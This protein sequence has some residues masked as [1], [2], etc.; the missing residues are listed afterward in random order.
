[1]TTPD[2]FPF[3]AR[4]VDVH[5]SRMHYIDE[6]DGA[7]VLFIHG[8]P[9]SSY[10]WRNVIPHV[11]P[12]ARAVAV[13][14]IG[15]GKSDQPDLPYRFTDHYRYLEG[16][17]DAL[18]LQ[19]VTLV[20][21]DWGGGLGTSWARRHPDRV[22]G[23]VFMESVLMPMDLADTDIVTRFVFNRM[24]DPKKGDRMN[25]QK[26]FFLKR[27]MPMMT[28]TRLSPAAKAAYLAPFSTPESRKPV[29]Q[30]PREIPLG[31]HPE[32]MV[33]EIGDNYEWFRSADIPKLLL[34]AEPGVIFK[35]IVP[36]IE[37][38]VAHLTS[39]SIGPGKHYVQ[40][41]QPDAIGTAIAE[42]FT[43]Q[44]TTG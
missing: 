28:K 40:E 20:L 32:D 43:T 12:H 14:L 19:D 7:P 1:M 3:D 2:E 36:D 10:L 21:H 25:M 16:F 5:G 29:A 30:W 18:D 44:L 31:G 41:D 37:R 6:G 42:W 4:F 23:I 15:M 39:I 38:D 9:T 34:H 8:N 26:A 22:R 27:L 11:T 24:R 17:I 35:G 33:R 13:D